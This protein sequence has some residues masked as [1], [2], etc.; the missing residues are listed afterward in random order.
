MISLYKRRKKAYEEFFKI[1]N[2]T[3]NVLLICYSYANIKINQ[4]DLSPIITSISI[5]SL[6]KNY[7]NKYFSLI[8][9]AEKANIELDE[10]EDNYEELEYFLLEEFN[11]FLKKHRDYIWIHWNMNQIDY[12][13]E[14]LKHRFDITAR[15]LDKELENIPANNKFDLNY[16]LENMYGVEYTK[17]SD[18]M[19]ALMK[20]NNYSDL[21]SYMSTKQESEQFNENQFS[22]V[23]NSI[24]SKMNFM[25]IIIE[26]L[27][28]KTLKIPLK[29][30][31]A[32]FIEFISHPL[33]SL[34]GWTATILG[35]I[36]TIIG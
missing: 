36:Y 16:L 13:F 3:S 21:K 19:K 6:D 34:V 7:E 28:N 12:G 27:E 32:I 26:K 23:R 2:D 10:L 9:E 30:N 4:S 15:E 8:K 24:N 35:T 20:E 5:R 17:D 18:R 22:Q 29:N 31:Y 33:F 11:V 1:I 25:F 14:A